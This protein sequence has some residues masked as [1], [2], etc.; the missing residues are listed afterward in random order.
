MS[1]KY[2]HEKIIYGFCNSANMNK[3]KW[4]FRDDFGYYFFWKYDIT[5]IFILLIV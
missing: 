1:I 2:F 3:Q 4:R 5:E